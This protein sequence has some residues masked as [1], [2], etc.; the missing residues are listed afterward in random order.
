MSSDIQAAALLIG[1]AGGGMMTM[2]RR[3]RLSRQEAQNQTRERLIEAARQ[4]FIRSGFAGTSLRDIATEAGFSQGAFYSNFPCKEA[5]LFELLKRH[6]ALDD[7]HLDAIVGDSERSLD[8]IL[9]VLKSWFE[10][11]ERDR[12]WSILT[13]ELQLHA[14]RSPT[15]A[16]SHARFWLE[17]EQRVAQLLSRTFAH[18]GKVVP[19][20]PT[21]LAAGLMA[22]A[23]G[24]AVQENAKHP[25]RT[26]ATIS[27]FLQA[28]VAAA[29]PDENGSVADADRH[30]LPSSLSQV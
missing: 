1:E 23:N 27:L 9:A 6:V 5:V 13:V 26:A 15:F 29:E 8:Q 10:K 24:L 11:F 28:L 19:A 30:V 12:D 21:Q 3:E 7:R 17:H 20:H 25:P 14:S 16:E 22:L 18:C 2:I 4:L